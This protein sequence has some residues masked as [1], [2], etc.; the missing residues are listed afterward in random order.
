M[1]GLVRWRPV[2]PDAIQ[3]RPAAAD[4][5]PDRFGSADGWLP[6]EKSYQHRLRA[7]RLGRR[8]H[9]A[10]AEGAWPGS[11]REVRGVQGRRQTEHHARQ[12]GTDLSPATHGQEH[13]SPSAARTEK[14]DSR[15]GITHQN[16]Q[17]AYP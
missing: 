5:A 9:P 8:A 6:P 1:E 11:A 12:P 3:E 16:D 7:A 13:D 10:L 4:L 17:E 2:D 14:R 15:Q